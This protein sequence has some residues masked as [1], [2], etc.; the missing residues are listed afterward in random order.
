LPEGFVVWVT[1]A[2]AFFSF[3]VNLLS[4]GSCRA[5]PYIVGRAELITN[6]PVSTRTISN[7]PSSNEVMCSSD[8]NVS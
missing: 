6:D 2:T 3:I 7:P 4:I 8:A 5:L 1:F